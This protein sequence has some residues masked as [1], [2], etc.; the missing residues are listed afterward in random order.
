MKAALG[1]CEQAPPLA[2]AQL[3]ARV[4]D[5]VELTKPRIA[6]LVLFTVAAGVLLAAGREVHWLILLHAVV[7][8]ALVAAGASA[9]NQLL[10][11]HSDSLMRRTENRPLPAGRLQPREVAVFGTLLG[12]VGI[13][14]LVLLLPTAGAA[15]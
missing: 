1:V 4:T 15:A 9:L 10:E 5:Y 14:Y 2:L 11:R 13:L 3:R 6:V 12:V 7:G 8:T